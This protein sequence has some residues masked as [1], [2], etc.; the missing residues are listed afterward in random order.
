M[1][2]NLGFPGTSHDY[3]EHYENKIDEDVAPF[4]HYLSQQPFY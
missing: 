4:L 2:S 1:W 3:A